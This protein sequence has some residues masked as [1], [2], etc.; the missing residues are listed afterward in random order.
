MYRDLI[1]VHG[2]QYFICNK[3]TFCFHKQVLAMQIRLFQ[4]TLL[5]NES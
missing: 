1:T 4:M 5:R 3:S 2:L